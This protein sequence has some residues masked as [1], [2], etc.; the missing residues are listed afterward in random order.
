[1]NP[2]VELLAR[3]DRVQNRLE[4]HAA[5]A[6]TLAGLTD[7]DERTGERWEAGQVFAHLAEFGDYWVHQARMV[8]RL[9][10]GE[11][12]PF[13]RVTTDAERVGAIE[14]DRRE[15]PLVLMAR[16]RHSMAAARDF[17][18]GLE[19]AAW[20]A[21]GMHSTLGVMDMAALLDAFIVGHYEQHC[22]QLEALVADA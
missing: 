16:S 6:N 4:H 3:L 17:I 14:R 10:D 21:R 13:G 18:G 1:M 8:L 19:G 12:V 9:Y 7:P 22:A 20:S 2:G 15:S 11:P 5:R